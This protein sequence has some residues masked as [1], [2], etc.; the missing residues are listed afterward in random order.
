[1]GGPLSTHHRLCPGTWLHPPTRGVFLNHTKVTKSTLEGGSQ[2]PVLNPE[3]HAE[4][5]SLGVL[6]PGEE[7]VQ[8]HSKRAPKGAYHCNAKSLSDEIRGK[9]ENGDW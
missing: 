1:M 7:I 3:A 8:R 9:R 5:F 4:G 2:L 6:T